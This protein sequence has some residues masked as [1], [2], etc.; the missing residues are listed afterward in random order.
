MRTIQSAAGFRPR[1]PPAVWNHPCWADSLT[2]W[3]NLVSAVS[4][5]RCLS[6]RRPRSTWG[7]RS[8]WSRSS[9]ASSRAEPPSCRYVVRQRP[10]VVTVPPGLNQIS[11]PVFQIITD[12]DMT[13]SKFSVNG[14]RCPTCHSESQHPGHQASPELWLDVNSHLLSKSAHFITIW[15]ALFLNLVLLKMPLNLL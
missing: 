1:A 10:L 11:P 2:H 8:G 7:T 15:M 9:A 14:K 5:S 4:P 3:L 12:F 6:S 13:L